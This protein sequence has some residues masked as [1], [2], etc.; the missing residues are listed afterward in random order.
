[1]FAVLSIFSQKAIS[2]EFNHQLILDK[3]NAGAGCCP[4]REGPRGPRGFTGATGPIGPT[5]PIGGID[6]WASFSIDP[7]SSVTYPRNSAAPLP[8]RSDNAIEFLF[9]APAKNITNPGAGTITIANPGTYQILYT[10]TGHFTTAS[11]N[12]DW[13]TELRIKC[14]NLRYTEALSNGV[15][16]ITLTWHRPL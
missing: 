13:F 11:A 2:A 7:S 14:T 1:M 9:Q 4:S 8:F 12:N 3:L 15:T 6:S 5:G 16:E 10:V